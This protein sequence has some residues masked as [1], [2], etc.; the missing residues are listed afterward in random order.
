M[1]DLG[2]QE[3]ASGVRDVTPHTHDEAACKEH[4]VRIAGLWKG[5]NDRA[6]DDENTSNRCT[7]PSTQNIG[8]VRREEQD[9][10]SSKAWEG[11]KKAES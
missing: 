4:R 3:W 7:R 11:S 9:G 5:L 10:E 2:N 6:D 8:D 1:R